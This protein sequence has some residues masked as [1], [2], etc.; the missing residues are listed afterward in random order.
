[1]LTSKGYDGFFHTQGGFPAKVKDSIGEYLENC[2][3]GTERW[4]DPSL[5]LTTYLKWN[6]DDKPYIVCDMWVRYKEGKFDL[7][8][9]DIQKKDRY[10]QLIRKSELQNLSTASMPKWADAV[11]TV[12]REHRQV[13]TPISPKKR[14]KL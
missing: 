12:N 8:K 14:F 4:P 5:M 11:A 1:M 6:G 3:L 2:E 10:G 7:R 9:M 13:Q